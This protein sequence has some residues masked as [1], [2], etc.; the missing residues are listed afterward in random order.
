M[1]VYRLIYASRV[2]PVEPWRLTGS[3]ADILLTSVR[4][5]RRDGITGFLLCD[6]GFFAQALEGPMRE[7]EDCFTRIFRDSRHLGPQV[8]ARGHVA[9]ALFPRWSMCG[10]RLSELDD[11]LLQ[12]G[13][14][15]FDLM[16]ASAG[17]LLQHLNGV[18]ERHGDALDAAHARLIVDVSRS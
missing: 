15:G 2:T 5:N 4:N 6:G 14:I 12:P 11:A 8:R 9:R 17:A 3:L 18:A 16:G 13:D 10:L 1:S 7:V